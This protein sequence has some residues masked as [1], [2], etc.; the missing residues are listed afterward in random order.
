MRLTITIDLDNA[1]FDDSGA[2]AEL[3][4]VLRQLDH[5]IGRAE[6]RDELP[7]LAPVRLHDSNGNAVG[8]VTIE[9]E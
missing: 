3:R 2:G 7:K 6:S 9:A 5:T 1:A 4:R 8:Q